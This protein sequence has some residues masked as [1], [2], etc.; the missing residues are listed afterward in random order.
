MTRG[1]RWAGAALVLFLAAACASSGQ[2]AG[3]WRFVSI[4]DFLNVDVAYPEPKW[5]DALGYV[6]EAIRAEKPDFVLVAGDLVM[7][8]WCDGPDQ[9][10]HLA[11][12][13]YGAWTRRMRD[14]GLTF[15]TAIG[16]HE[17]GDNPWPPAKAKLVP[18]FKKAFRDHLKM[19]LNGPPGFKGTAWWRL[20]KGTLLVAVDVFTPDPGKGIRTT[21]A[22][23]QLAWLE[24]T[25][26]DHSDA[27]HVVVMGHTPIVAPVRARASSRL[28]LEGG[29]R[30][31]LWQT[32]AKH[33]ADLYLCG[34]VHTITCTQAD[35]VEQIAHGSL[36]GYVNTV[37]YLVATV[38]PTRMDLELKR[39][40]IV[41]EGGRMYQE[42]R[43][44]PRETVR[45]T[46]EAKA[47]GFQRVGTLVIDKTGGARRFL[48]A[49][50]EF[51]NPYQPRGGTRRR[52]R[53]PQGAPRGE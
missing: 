7:G 34:E 29:R 51:A 26:A 52:P 23:E 41:C 36:F 44:R 15:Y 35:G 22:G 30:S 3:P 2:D 24:R 40:P 25:L 12:L 17:V 1:R 6:L 46:P 49:T 42:G 20:H 45:I 27:D 11:H 37:N 47:Q 31:P 53:A 13:Y 8:R 10:E 18:H 19:P 16:D 14:H 4:P 32:L 38:W 9:I 28:M 39:L 50:G 5:E 33:G 43:N 21:V 48:D